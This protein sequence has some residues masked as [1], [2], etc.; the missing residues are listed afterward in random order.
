MGTKKKA[1]KSAKKKKYSFEWGYIDTPLPL[2]NLKPAEKKEMVDWLRKFEKL[3]KMKGVS[4]RFIGKHWDKYDKMLMDCLDL[5][6]SV[7]D[8]YVKKSLKAGDE[9]LLPLA[10]KAEKLLQVHDGIED[11]YIKTSELFFKENKS[12]ITKNRRLLKKEFTAE[13]AVQIRKNMAF[14]A[15]LL[16]EIRKIYETMRLYFDAVEEFRKAT[17]KLRPN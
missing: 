9:E 17:A 16:T 7:E 14:T 13:V 1:V 6:L 3:E 4:S 8:R 12:C 5:L 15:E 10:I 11:K 2:Q